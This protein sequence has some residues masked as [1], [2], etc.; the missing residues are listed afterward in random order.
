MERD[1]VHLPDIS[2]PCLPVGTTEL[3]LLGTFPTRAQVPAGEDLATF[4][5][6]KW[7]LLKTDPADPSIPARRHLIRVVEVEPT[8]DPLSLDTSNQSPRI[9]RIKWQD[10]Q[11]LPFEMCLTDMVVRGNLVFATAGETVTEFFSWQQR[12]IPSAL[13]QQ[14]DRASNARGPST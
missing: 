7:L 3:F 2:T 11:A 1:T 8:T 5:T 6:G 13:A 14:V 10:E 9:T 12:D 4:W